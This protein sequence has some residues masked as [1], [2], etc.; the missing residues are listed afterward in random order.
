MRLH[1]NNG[2][3]AAVLLPGHQLGDDGG[4]ATVQRHYAAV[5]RLRA[6]LRAEVFEHRASSGDI[7]VFDN[8][9]V[10]HGRNAFVVAERELEGGYIEWDDVLSLQRLLVAHM[11]RQDE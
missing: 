6:A 4:V 7:W 1:L 8:K 9:R 10:L 2:V 3:R 5:Q 11:P